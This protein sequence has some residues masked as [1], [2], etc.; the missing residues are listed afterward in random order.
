[1]GFG[2]GKPWGEP[3]GTHTHIVKPSPLLKHVQ[4]Y[5]LGEWGYNSQN[6]RREGGRAEGKGRLAQMTSR[7]ASSVTLINKRENNE[8][9]KEGKKGKK[10]MEDRGGNSRH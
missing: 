1:L 4:L 2:R 9:K 3:E 7:E 10:C 5:L 6:L 8:G